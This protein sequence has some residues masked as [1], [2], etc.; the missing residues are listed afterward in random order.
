MA[1]CRLIAD[2]CY[3]E[4]ASGNNNNKRKIL[5]FRRQLLLPFDDLTLTDLL[6]IYFFFIPCLVTT[7]LGSLTSVG[8]VISHHH[9]G[10]PPPE[11][12]WPDMRVEGLATCDIPRTFLSIHNNNNQLGPTRPN[13]SQLAPTRPNSQLVPNFECNFYYIKCYNLL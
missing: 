6:F 9:R 7:S 8:R 5:R 13:S 10:E 12:R 3:S 4:D 2:H 11:N 1:K